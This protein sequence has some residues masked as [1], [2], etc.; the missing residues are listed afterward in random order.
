ME[1][2]F[3][4]LDGSLDAEVTARFDGGAEIQGQ[5][6][7]QDGVLQI[8]AIGQRFHDV[9]AQ[10]SMQREQVTLDHF[11]ARGIAGRLTARGQAELEGFSLQSAQLHARI[12]E[13]EKLPL[14]LQG[15]PLGEAWGE[16]DMQLNSGTSTDSADVTVRVTEFHVE[17]P[18]AA[19]RGVRSLE[20]AEYI[21]VGVRSN[22][23][24]FVA[25]PLQPIEESDAK[26]RDLIMLEVVLGPSVTI[27]KGNQARVQLS[28][29]LDV[30][31]DDSTRLA[32]ELHAT[33]GE[34]DVSGKTFDL[35][36]ATVT[37][38]IDR[39]AEN[40]TIFALARWDSPDGITVYAQ[41]V[42]NVSEGSL[43]LYSEPALTDDQIL[44]LLL[45][46]TPDGA[47]GGTTGNSAAAAFG[48]V[49]GSA[50]RGLNRALESFTNLD[51]STRVDTSTGSARPELVVQ[52]TPRLSAH[53][54]RALGEPYI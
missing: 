49:G 37:F 54:T 4:E 15:V 28:G 48:V 23:G 18:D 20:P 47:L 26:E 45:L 44:S 39:P 6:T 12:D 31:L 9:S 5:A 30:R 38:D 35:E 33:S 11:S 16:L 1:G 22:D 53:V 51:V 42:G 43:T 50:T 21:Q 52:L 34:L 7:V 2:T 13:D 8:P 19:P 24:R 14:T 10:L 41:Y 3:S 25:I 46:G 29:R 32:G 27:E 17:L 40:P 36:R